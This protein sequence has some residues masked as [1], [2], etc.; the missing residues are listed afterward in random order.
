MSK[1]EQGNSSGSVGDRILA[2]LT[3]Q[4]ISQLLDVLFAVL[5]NETL[6]QVLAQLQANTQETVQQ[7]LTP[8]QTDIQTEV[9][10]EQPVSLAKLAQTWS[11]LWQEWNEI[12]YEAAEEEGRY[13][14]QEASWEQ[15]YFDTYTLVEDLE[16]VAAQM[17]PL[18][19]TAFKHGFTPDNDFASAL[20][21]AES[22]I[23]NGI[24]EW[25]HIEGF[26]L[27]KHLTACFLEWEWL[28]IQDEGKD[29]FDFALQIR[30]WENR[31]TLVSLERSAIIDFFTKL[32][33]PQKQCIFAGLTADRTTPLWQGTLDNIH[34]HWYQVYINLVHQYK[35]E[36]YLE[37]LRTT[38]PQKWQNGLLV[39]EDLL[40]KQDYIESL[41]VIEET[42]NALLKFK[43]E[44]RSWSPETSLL[45][46]E[47][48]DCYTTNEG[49]ES[50]KMLLRYYQQ[51]AQGLGQTERMNALEI[52]RIAFEHRYDWSVM[53]K[54]F[55]EV[56]VSNPTRQALFQSWRDYIARRTRRQ[57][58][59]FRLF[60]GVK[61]VETWW[62]HWLIN[63]I[64]SSKKGA[65][66]FQ[67]EISEWLES[68]LKDRR[69]LSEAYYILRLLT[70]D[71]TE[72]HQ[73]D[74]KPYPNF[75]QVVIRPNELSTAD[76]ASRQGYLQDYT[77]KD[78][79]EQVMVFWTA[80]L[81]NFV[82]KPENAQKS[83][84]TNHAQW[85]AALKEL[86]PQAYGALLAQWKTEHQ[87][88][89]NLWKAMGELGL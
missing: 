74:R 77:S 27:E 87:R 17:Q 20:L 32:S 75:Y 80:Q 63:S 13:I 14:E 60:G 79:W 8:S 82:P 40:A 4:E 2:A 58:Q 68:L 37:N 10:E 33:D 48:G 81:H 29:G 46:T 24:P 70:K 31:F 42:L 53:F 19:H 35:P 85:M 22:E 41:T 26:E 28:T 73:T 78:L 51:T 56:P 83:D 71:L 23:S 39:I 21:E 52:Q 30:Q 34:S 49:A 7:I 38:I 62:L 18:I 69:Q 54:A 15:P 84:Y 50:E 44:D 61:T 55:A 86:N 36:Q 89:R 12:I 16:Q 45:F 9:T 88:R 59:S 43:Q 72:I 3:E 76:E 64:A 5:S 25:M 57:S 66:W 47:N 6:S 67:E 65:T 11:Q 1:Q